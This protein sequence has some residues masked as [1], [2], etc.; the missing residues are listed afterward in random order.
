MVLIGR[1]DT[2][3]KVYGAVGAVAAGMGGNGEEVGI[4]SGDGS[5]DGTVADAIPVPVRG[6]KRLW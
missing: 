1:T 2:P 3:E 5:G 4:V 6:T